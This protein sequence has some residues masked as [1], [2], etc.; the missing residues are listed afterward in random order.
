MLTT[1]VACAGDLFGNASQ[2]LNDVYLKFVGMST[3]A[4]GVG[5]G[6][7]V[8][9][10]KLSFGK[11]GNSYMRQRII[12]AI[13]HKSTDLT[14]WHIDLTSAFIEKLK[15][16]KACEDAEAFLENHLMRAKYKRN[17]KLN[18]EMEMNLFGVKWIKSTDGGDVGNIVDSPL[19]DDNFEGYK[20]P[21]IEKEFAIELCKTLEN[22]KRNAFRMFSI[23]MGYFER[24]WSL[25]GMENILM[26]MLLNE[27]FTQELFENILNHHLQLLDVVLDY[28]FEGVYIGDDWGQQQGLIM[29]PNMWRKYIK[30]GIS[31]IFEKIKSKGKYIILHSC[32]DLREILPDLIEMGLD[33][34]NTIQPEIY[35]LNKLKAEYGKHLTFYGAISTQQFLPFASPQEVRKKTEDVLRLMG[36]DGGYILSPTHAVTPDIPVENILTM[37][38]VAKKMKW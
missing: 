20:F 26:D 29:G 12:D 37:I 30:S 1:N 28:N 31:K 17:I 32:G 18:D 24:A 36:K 14:P 4:A 2:L 5:V 34:Y 9:M 33:V 10:K 3:A 35:D 38:E 6:T 25:R 19:K 11:E 22:E 27:A 23:T 8:F 7:G 13:N 16:E 15:K 21:N